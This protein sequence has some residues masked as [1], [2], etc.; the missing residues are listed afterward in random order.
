MIF[1]VQ[2]YLEDYFHHCGLADPDQY[3]VSVAKLYDRKR[4]HKTA[5]AFLVAM[6]RV[7]TS[8]YRRN[9]Q[10]RRE[11]FERMLLTALD[12]KFKKKDYSPFQEQSPPRLKLQARG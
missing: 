12:G 6:K 8:F 5:A 10:T 7:R 2:R 4:Y 9:R 1:D 11:S 3:A